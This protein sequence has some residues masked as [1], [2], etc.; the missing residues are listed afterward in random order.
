VVPVGA[1]RVEADLARLAVQDRLDPD[2]Y[3]SARAAGR[4]LGA[5]EALRLAQ[6][7]G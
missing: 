1:E 5:E 2:A 3:R 6:A 4:R 7:V